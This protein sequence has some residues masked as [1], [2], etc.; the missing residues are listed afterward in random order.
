VHLRLVFS[1][2]RAQYR[3]HRSLV[4]VLRAFREQR[5]L[6]ASVN[7]R[8]AHVRT[9]ERARFHSKSVSL[10]GRRLNWK[11]GQR[12]P[13]SIETIAERQPLMTS[14]MSLAALSLILL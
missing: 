7:A 2:E 8:A 14:S 3:D 4:R 10:E 5:A 6:F 12:Q 1:V 11:L 13:R 9:V